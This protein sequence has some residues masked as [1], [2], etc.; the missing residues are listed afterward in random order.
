MK[1]NVP[2]E[3]RGNSSKRAQAALKK[4]KEIEKKIG[5][6][7]KEL[8]Q[9]EYTASSGGGV[10]SVVVM[11]SLEIKSIKID[12]E[13]VNKED[14]PMLS[15]LIISALNEAISTA[16]KEKDAILDTQTS[17]VDLNAM[18]GLM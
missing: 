8:D 6:Q 7:I 18:L 15:D 2:K 4:A 3:L 5:E 10:V 17:G 12:P 1:A 13:V 14:I 9:K 11:G 16:Q